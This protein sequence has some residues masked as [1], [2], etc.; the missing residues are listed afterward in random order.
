MEE[1]GEV[2]SAEGRRKTR[3]Q[4]EVG[5]GRWGKGDRREMQEG[6]RGKG[7]E[8][9]TKVEQKRNVEGNVHGKCKKRG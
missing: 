7:R 1:D 9:W 3:I 4:G 6:K 2:G 8:T 5:C